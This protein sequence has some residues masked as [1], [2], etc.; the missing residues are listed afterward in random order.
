MHKLTK[1]LN[2]AA[3]PC[4]ALAVSTPSSAYKFDLPGPYSAQL[5]TTLTYGAMWRLDD[6]NDLLMSD[7]NRDDANNNFD[8][9]LVSNSLR[10]VSELELSR[11]FKSGNELG[12]FTR[13]TA[14]YDDKIAGAENDNNNGLTLNSSSLYNGSLDSRNEFHS[15]TE[16]RIG[17]NSELLDLFVY[18][19]FGENTEHSGSLRVG[20]QVVSWGESSLIQ[21]GISAAINPADVSKVALPGVEVK[22][23][24][25]PVET[26]YGSI[27]VNENL[28]LS[29]YYQFK[30][31]DSITSPYGA[32][33]NPLPDFISTD[34]SESLL[35]PV[36]MGIPTADGLAARFGLPP[37]SAEF[38]TPFAAVE[39]ISD[40]DADDDGQWGIALNWYLPELAGTELGFFFINYHSKLPSLIVDSFSGTQDGALSYTAQ[41]AVY[42]AS[43]GSPAIPGGPLAGLGADCAALSLLGQGVDNAS[44]RT[45]F[46]EDIRAYAVSWN[47]LISFT[48]TAFSGEIAYHE[49]IP[50]QT[51]RAL[52]GLLPQTVGA[53]IATGS[54]VTTELST[55]EKLLVTQMTFLQNFN[56]LPFADSALLLAE[57]GWVHAVDLD[58]GELTTDTLGTPWAAE[59]DLW[60]GNS[61]ADKD[62]WGYRLMLEMTWFE[63][64]GRIAE[65]FS[66]DTLT[67]TISISHDVEGTSPLLTGF[68]DNQKAVSV[69][70]QASWMN[71]IHV[72]LTYTNFF[73]SGTDTLGNNIDK[74]VLD[75][76]DNLA[77]TLRY[78]F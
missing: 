63:R 28:S 40:E 15:D 13:V 55:R 58:D 76:Q 50:L 20:K 72:G 22:E 65:V 75:D 51:T 68:V 64:L 47:T 19:N 16:D 18:Y 2:Y 12:L 25:R 42:A 62:S 56:N 46:E 66:G 32:Y 14:L 21:T 41:C 27:T 54:P 60:V 9:G 29:A 44:L 3:L 24:L 61:I 6:R 49:N 23:I 53:S 35:A 43:G 11:Q 10:L 7:I 33:L 34:G 71:A 52:D 36:A 78:Q 57:L 4:V 38:A 26:V 69:G 70:L 37:Q 31:E 67:G 30:W 48:D 59:G 39:R 74:H 77:L 8:K 73:G 45:A 1:Y 17:R 5:D